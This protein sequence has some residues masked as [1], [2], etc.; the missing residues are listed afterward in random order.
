MTVK[1]NKTQTQTNK[2]KT[3][4]EKPPHHAPKGKYSAERQRSNTAIW[5]QTTLH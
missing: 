2:Q 3:T 4:K 1:K 5:L